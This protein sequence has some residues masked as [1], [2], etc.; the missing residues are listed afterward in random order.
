M[1]ITCKHTL[2][3]GAK[4]REQIPAIVRAPAPPLQLRGS[5]PARRGEN[6]PRFF[7]P[8]SS[9][10]P[11]KAPKRLCP[12]YVAVLSNKSEW[13]ERE[14]VREMD[15]NRGGE[16]HPL[17]ILLQD[18][19]GVGGAMHF[20]WQLEDGGMS[21]GRKQNVYILMHDSN[22]P[23][24][25]LLTAFGHPPSLPP[26]SSSFLTEE[27]AHPTKLAATRVPFH[28]PWFGIKSCP[29]PSSKYSLGGRAGKKWAP[30]A[31][32]TFSVASHFPLNQSKTTKMCLLFRLE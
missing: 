18:W 10:V 27:P 20:S 2:R 8:L 29:C 26:R 15:W 3:P 25:L 13:A 5:F 19:W 14:E 28:Q 12:L 31:V 30:D 6:T 21:D 17:S 32:N 24:I 11:Q 16:K 22:K 4:A 7:R 1:I 23:F 9:A